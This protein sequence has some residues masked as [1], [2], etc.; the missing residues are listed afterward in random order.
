MDETLIYYNTKRC[1]VLF[2]EVEYNVTFASDWF[3]FNNWCETEHE[4]SPCITRS[5]L[6]SERVPCQNDDV[7]FS[8]DGSYFVNLESNIE[9]KINTLKISGRV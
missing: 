6:D 7:V 9:V 5:M 3:D 1:Y 4:S 2:P 8:R